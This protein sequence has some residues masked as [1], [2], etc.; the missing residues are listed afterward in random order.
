MRIE[1]TY[2]FPTPLERVFAALTEADVLTRAVPGCERLIQ[3][4]PVGED[5]LMTIEM[6]LRAEAGAA[7]YTTTAEILAL[8]NP[9]QL[10]LDVHGLGPAGP[11]AA[12]G[13]LRLV[14]EDGHTRGL[15]RWEVEPQGLCKE[16]QMALS[17]GA[18]QRLAQ[19]FCERVDAALRGST[20]NDGA[21]NGHMP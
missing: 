7:I 16:H 5:G 15:Y 20:S 13:T 6:R 19:T 21:S 11:I 14:E 10:R 12:H 8:R 4:G 18:G 9:A 17:D 2:T 3:L 1:G